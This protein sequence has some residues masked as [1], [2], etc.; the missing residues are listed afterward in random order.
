MKNIL[1]SFIT[2]LLMAVITTDAFAS[3][4]RKYDQAL[5][6]Y[7]ENLYTGNEG[8]VTSSLMH[9]IVLAD[10]TDEYDNEVASELQEFVRLHAD[11][12]FGYKAYLALLAINNPKVLEQVEV[13]TSG[14]AVAFFA[15]LAHTVNSEVFNETEL[16]SD[17]QLR[18]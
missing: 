12:S 5:E 16:T 18:E 2:I 8:V 15:E 6:N 11:S 7:I 17:A 1:F 13:T 14:Q 10:Y 3:E 9:L 4:D